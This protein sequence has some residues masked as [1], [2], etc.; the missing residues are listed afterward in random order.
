MNEWLR[1]LIEQ[2]KALWGRWTVTQRIILMVV[3]G[4]VLVGIVMIVA[5]SAV[6]I[7]EMFLIYLSF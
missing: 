6:I 1:K 7:W 4:A 3:V 5:F 2:I